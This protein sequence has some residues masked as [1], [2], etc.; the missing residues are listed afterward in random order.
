MMIFILSGD[1]L[2]WRGEGA[3]NVELNY[4]D[5]K[6]VVL[7]FCCLVIGLMRLVVLCFEF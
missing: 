7:W 1:A 6:W 3:T 4:R 2:W 5:F